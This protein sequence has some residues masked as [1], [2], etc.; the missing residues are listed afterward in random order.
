MVGSVRKIAS[1]GHWVRALPHERKIVIAGNHDLAFERRPERAREAL[2]DGRDGLTYLQDSGLSIDGVAFW[3]SPWQ[4]AFLNWAFN[5]PRGTLL[6]QKWELIPE[7][8][9]V[10]VTHGPPMR[11]RDLVNNEHLGCADLRNRIESVRPKVHA[12]GHIHAASG[13]EVIGG[14][15]FVN[16][17]ICDE[18]YNASNPVRVVDI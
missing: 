17:S 1:F 10:L 7:Q 5:L 12:F 2:G 18:D 11:I 16:A 3:G 8:T 13:I 15:V 6:A 4:P 9:D 14:T